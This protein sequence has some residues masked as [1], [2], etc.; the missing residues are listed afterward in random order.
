MTPLQASILRLQRS[1]QLL[2]EGTVD[3][4]RAMGVL[5]DHYEG[6]FV[7][8]PFFTAGL[9]DLLT[10]CMHE[11]PSGFTW[12]NTASSAV[13]RLPSD[14]EPTMW[15]AAGTPCTGVYVPVWVA[16]GGVPDIMGKAGIRPGTVNPELAEPDRFD[17]TSYWWR[18]LQLLESVKGGELALRFAE[19]QPI[20]RAAF[21]ALEE[22][23][24]DEA[25]GVLTTAQR[26]V[27]EGPDMLA[28]YTQACCDEAVDTVERL[29]GDF[30]EPLDM[31]VDPRWAPATR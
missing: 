4:R 23:W 13:C 26:R 31:I 20:V 22:R 28:A 9:P 21:D 27:A 18:F 25:P 10:L 30:A 2:A 19:R 8:G 15:W 14:G 17:R 1:R 5:R 16:A 12:G 11:H 6:T 24:L 3:E 29:L 7:S